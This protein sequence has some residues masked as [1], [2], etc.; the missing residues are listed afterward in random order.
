[1]VGHLGVQLDQYSSTALSSAFWK[2]WTYSYRRD[3]L[4]SLKHPVHHYTLPVL[5]M[6][7]KHLLTN[8][9]ISITNSSSSSV[10]TTTV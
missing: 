3:S 5:W 9:S 1:M 8:I 2:D 7:I 10:I 6:E 4:S